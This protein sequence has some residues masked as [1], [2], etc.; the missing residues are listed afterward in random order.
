[1][2]Q[3]D[4]NYSVDQFL[5]DQIDTVPHLEALLLLWNSRPKAWTVVDMANALFLAPRSAREIL[6]DLVRQRLIAP[7]PE[8]GESYRYEPEPEKDQ[9]LASVDATYRRELVRI[10]VLIHSRPSTSSA[11]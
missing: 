10:S 9:L 8:T 11:L 5:R 6:G 7:V 3:E 2:E 4:G 1:M